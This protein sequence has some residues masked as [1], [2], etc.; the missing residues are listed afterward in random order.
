MILKVN[1]LCSEA[2][3]PVYAT[4]GSAGLDVFAHLGPGACETLVMLPGEVHKVPLGFACE[5]EPGYCAY[6]QGRSSHNLAGF[7]SIELGLI[8]SDYRGEVCAI[9]R[10]NKPFELKNGLKVAQMVMRKVVRVGV[11]VVDELSTTQR[12]TGGFG[13]SGNA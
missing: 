10:C 6:V 3:P 11:R 9:V 2:K 1:L 13:S 5:I 4:V 7:F 12:G 8:D